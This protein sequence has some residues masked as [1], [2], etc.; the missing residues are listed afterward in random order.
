[1]TLHT[2]LRGV[3]LNVQSQNV[4]CFC[5]KAYDIARKVL[6]FATVGE[7][8]HAGMWADGDRGG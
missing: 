4:R 1:M 5:D 7:R 3:M 6:R 2:K 8:R